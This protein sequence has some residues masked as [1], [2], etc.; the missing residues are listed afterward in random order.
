MMKKISTAFVLGSVVL[1]AGCQQSTETPPTQYEKVEAKLFTQKLDQEAALKMVELHLL[2][3][4]DYKNKQGSNLVLKNKMTL[5]G[6]NNWNFTF[7]FNMPNTN[8]LGQ[9]IVVVRNGKINDVKFSERTND[10]SPVK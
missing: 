1:L 9:F 6:E 2:N 7:Q 8:A 5:D 3:E 10:G 4:A